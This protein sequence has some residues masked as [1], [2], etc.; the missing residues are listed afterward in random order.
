M[1][2]AHYQPAGK[3]TEEAKSMQFR[4]SSCAMFFYNQHER[5]P[6]ALGVE[7]FHAAIT[8]ATQTTSNFMKD[9]KKSLAIDVNRI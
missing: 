9:I 4:I 2:I 8:F 3:A 5:G 7:N 1:Q 6:N